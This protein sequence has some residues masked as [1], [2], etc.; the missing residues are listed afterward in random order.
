MAVVQN[1]TASLVIAGGSAG[2]LDVK[3]AVYITLPSGAIVE[4]INVKPGGSPIFEDQMD[5]LG[6]LHTR[7][8]FEKGMHQHTTTIVG[9]EYTKAAGDVDG[10]SSNYYVEG[11][12][13]A[14]G[15]AAVR[16]TI[17]G[18]RIPTIA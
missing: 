13:V 3:A 2:T 4:S 17:N 18:T 7:L 5:A 16:T 14:Y 10:S 12:D 15:K 11:V 1:G 9:K 8:T 6:A